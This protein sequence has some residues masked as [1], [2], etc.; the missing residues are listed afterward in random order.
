M[1]TSR[2]RGTVVSVTP[3]VMP[4]IA[5]VGAGDKQTLPETSQESAAGDVV[6]VIVVA[7]T[8]ISL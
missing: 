3:V 2:R 8:L 6:A 5:Y 1:S 7:N 4:V